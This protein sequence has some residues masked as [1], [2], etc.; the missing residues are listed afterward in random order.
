LGEDEKTFVL[1]HLLRC[2]NIQ[3]NMKNDFFFRL[4]P[5]A[6]V[7]ILS[8]GGCSGDHPA[9]SGKDTVKSAYKSIIDT[10]HTSRTNLDTAKVTTTTGSAS[11]VDDGGS[12]GTGISKDTAKTKA[13]SKK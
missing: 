8:T 12:G 3:Q 4:I 5:A 13:K 2:N 10:A 6:L 11:N 9:N 1:I 7:I